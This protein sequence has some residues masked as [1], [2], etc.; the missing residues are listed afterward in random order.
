MSISFE[1]FLEATAIAFIRKLN[2]NKIF[3]PFLNDPD[4]FISKDKCKKRTPNS[5]FLCRLN[6]QE[7]ARSIGQNLNMRIISKATSILWN[8]AS[9]EEKNEYIKLAIRVKN[10][11]ENASLENKEKNQ[12][13]INTYHNF[14]SS[15]EKIQNNYIS[16]EAEDTLI[17]SNNIQTFTNYINMDII[18]YWDSIGN[19]E[20]VDYNYC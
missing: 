13:S 7:E 18:E 15:Q 19:L 2:R 14:S 17:T 11:Y 6:V 12:D 10:C 20:I 16:N 3:P 9:D 8:K 4:R 1:S 5:F